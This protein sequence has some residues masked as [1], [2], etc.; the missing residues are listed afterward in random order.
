MAPPPAK[1]LAELVHRGD[2]TEEQARMAEEIP[3]AQ[4]LTAEADSAGHTDNRSLVDLLPI[5][6]SLRDRSQAQDSSLQLFFDR[7]RHVMRRGEVS[8]GAVKLTV[9]RFEVTNDLGIQEREIVKAERSPAVKG[10]LFKH[11]A[12][13][14]TTPDA[15]QHGAS[16]G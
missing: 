8:A 9:E 13:T 3:M 1:L 4:D 15:D 16:L 6:T 2:I 12:V 5:M 7:G 10:D 14:C 11:I